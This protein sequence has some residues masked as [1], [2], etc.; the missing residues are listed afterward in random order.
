MSDRHEDAYYINCVLQGDR[1]SFRELVQRYQG[2]VYRIAYS[3]VGIPESAS[4][5]VQEVFYRAYRS[6]DSYQHNRP[7]GAWIR[8]ITVNYMLD[9]RK[10]R[11]IQAYSLTTEDAD[12]FDVPDKGLNPREEQHQAEKEETVLKAIDKLPNKYRIILMLRHF[13]HLT[14]EE[15]A[16]TLSLPLGTVMTHIHRA[17]NK[18]A[19]ILE[20]AQTELY[21]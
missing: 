5:A 16:D 8:R 1:D 12:T 20:P 17:R 18:L 11:Q 21:S 9:Q 7:F 2:M 3:M 14:Y 19:K 6:L 13:E 10:K 15:I 4:D